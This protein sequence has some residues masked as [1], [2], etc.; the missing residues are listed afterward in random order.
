M[1]EFK[2]R[3]SETETQ[4]IKD[5]PPKKP[6]RFREMLA[7]TFKI[8]GE[9]YY[10]DLCKYIE[11][12]P[13]DEEIIKQEITEEA[14][15]IIED[16]VEEVVQ[17]LEAAKTALD[18]SDM[19]NTIREG[20]IAEI[21]KLEAKNLVL[22]GETTGEVEK[23]ANGDN[24][25]VG[26]NTTDEIVPTEKPK[27][28]ITEEE[29]R[30]KIAENKR[31]KADTRKKHKLKNKIGETSIGLSDTEEIEEPAVEIPVPPDTEE[32]EEPVAGTPVGETP[33]T[34]EPVVKKTPVAETPVEKIPT[35]STPS[36]ETTE[37]KLFYEDL[38][39][40]EGELT[41][42]KEAISLINML[43]E[44]SFDP[45]WNE[46]TNSLFEKIKTAY[47]KNSSVDQ[48]KKVDVVSELS[49]TFLDYGDNL[50]LQFINRSDNKN[51][52]SKLAYE[53]FGIDQILDIND[54]FRNSEEFNTFNEFM[55][56]NFNMEFLLPQLDSPFNQK[57]AD[58]VGLTHNSEMPANYVAG[59]DLL[60]IRRFE[61]GENGK[62]EPKIIRK[63]QVITQM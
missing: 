63:A 31:K 54:E 21:D 41:F 40:N 3:Q 18:S 29:R 59:V 60:G 62:I 57:E 34:E 22:A 11:Y 6:G 53:A 4:N 39:L 42:A 48:D 12:S 37:K 43:K 7:N 13:D 36:K 38:E 14:K 58:L 47:Q 5:I 52:N 50:M 9:K 27:T 33:T 49:T 32:I 20:A 55:K 28:Y 16:T 23:T 46:W 10:D 19:P 1:F 30:R 25:T 45:E 15:E 51:K 44:K 26:E 2:K 8:G 56:K 35:E 61:K 24:E 17:T